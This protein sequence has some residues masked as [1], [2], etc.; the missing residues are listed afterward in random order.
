MQKNTTIIPIFQCIR[1]NVLDYIY[2]IF[3]EVVVYS[4]Y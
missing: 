4:N 1:F 3:K 2:L